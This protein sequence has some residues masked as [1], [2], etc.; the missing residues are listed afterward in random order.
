MK[1]I[2]AISLAAIFVCVAAAAGVLVLKNRKDRGGVKKTTY[3][4]YEYDGISCA[5]DDPDYLL[6]NRF[7]QYENDGVSVLIT[8]DNYEEYGDGAVFFSKYFDILR[9]GDNEEY[10]NCFADGVYNNADE[11]REFTPQRI[12][13]I[14]IEDVSDE[15]KLRYVVRYK[16]LKN[17]G[18][19][20]TDIIDD[21]YHPLVFELSPG[22]D[23]SLKISDIYEYYK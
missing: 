9:R 20:R 23:G 3:I 17:D 15:E 1:K 18:S 10:K 13:D 8:D 19:F 4:F 6:C 11:I 21:I 22:S 5:D 14:I 2:I 12:Y 7:M 16:I